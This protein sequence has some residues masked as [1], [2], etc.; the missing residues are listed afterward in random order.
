MAKNTVF[1]LYIL[2]FSL[3][4]VIGLLCRFCNIKLLRILSDHLSLLLRNSCLQNNPWNDS[5]VKNVPFL[6]LV[7]ASRGPTLRKN[8]L[9]KCIKFQ[10]RTEIPSLIFVYSVRDVKCVESELILTESVCSSSPLQCVLRVQIK[11]LTLW[12]ADVMPGTPL[13]HWRRDPTLG[14]DNPEP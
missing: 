1:I 4:T 3:K 11:K 8:Q 13:T 12:V 5:L 9:T 14:G 10:S 7:W 6:V 2:C